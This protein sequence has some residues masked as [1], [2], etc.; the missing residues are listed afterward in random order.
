M[1]TKLI[2]AI[3]AVALCAAALVGVSAAQFGGAQYTTNPAQTQ[4]VPPCANSE[5]VV[6]PYCINATTGEP[7]CYQNGT[8]T[9]YCYNGNGVVGGYCGGGSCYGYGAQT[10]NQN[11]NQYGYGYGAGMMGRSSG[12]Y[13]CMGRS[14]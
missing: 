6:P 14:C 8:Y 12:G 1:K 9:G 10:Q 13:G 11:Q 4:G 7:Y 2:L 3:V 5:G